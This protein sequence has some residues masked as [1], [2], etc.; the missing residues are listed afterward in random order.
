MG[1][2]LDSRTRKHRI[3][4]GVLT[5]TQTIRLNK[6][7]DSES[8]RIDLI[9]DARGYRS[10]HV[11]MERDEKHPNAVLTTISLSGVAVRERLLGGKNQEK[12]VTETG[13]AF[14]LDGHDSWMLYEEAMFWKQCR[15]LNES[16]WKN[17][18]WVNGKIPAQYVSQ[19]D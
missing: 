6:I 9:Q 11:R 4:G 12:V 13:K 14:V 2:G 3:Q 10:I 18:P 5:M 16:E 15:Q 1:P 17:G 8:Y 7:V 19:N